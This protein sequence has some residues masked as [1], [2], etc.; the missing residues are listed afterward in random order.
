MGEMNYRDVEL[1]SHLHNETH[2][3]SVKA[4]A[5]VCNVPYS[6]A[7]EALRKAG[8]ENRKGA[9]HYQTIG[10][11]SSLG[12]TAVKMVIPPQVRTIKNARLAT[13][14]R[15]CLVFVRGHVAAMINGKVE[16]WTHGRKHRITSMYQI[17]ESTDLAG[18]SLAKAAAA[19]YVPIIEPPKPPK[20]RTGE[21][22]DQ[23]GSRKGTQSAN[24]NA[25]MTYDWQWIDKIADNAEV[26]TARVSAH[27]AW[28]I[29]RGFVIKNG[30][31]E[32]KLIDKKE[33]SND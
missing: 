1:E 7:H 9:Y 33:D 13:D 11:I 24:I 3:C 27:M 2:D 16:D 29:D 10:A 22:Y 31:G 14:H 26:S 5:L 18:I 4:T 17:F 25:V 21:K 8:R 23:F 20:P 19:R 15:S 12:F 32:F 30:Y 28:L 6:V